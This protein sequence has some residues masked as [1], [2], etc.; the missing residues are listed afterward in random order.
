MAEDGNV[1]EALHVLVA[2]TAQ[3]QCAT[4]TRK[5]INLSLRSISLDIPT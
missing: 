5:R 3:S 2:S 4:S 1:K